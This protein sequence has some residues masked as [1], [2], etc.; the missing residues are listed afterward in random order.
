MKKIKMVKLQSSDGEIH[1]QECRAKFCA[2]APGYDEEEALSL[3][4]KEAEKPLFLNHKQI[5]DRK[6]KSEVSN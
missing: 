2:T 4:K 3:S 1:F 5:A 6:T